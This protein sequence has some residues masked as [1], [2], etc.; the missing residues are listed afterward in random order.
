M[1]NRQ[2]Q[3]FDRLFNKNCPTKPTQEDVELVKDSLFL[4]P[5][6]AEELR[7]FSAKAYR[8]LEE[9]LAD[10]IIFIEGEIDDEPHRILLRDMAGMSDPDAEPIVVNQEHTTDPLEELVYVEEES[11]PIPDEEDARI[12]GLRNILDRYSKIHRPQDVI[13]I[14]SRIRPEKGDE[15]LLSPQIIR[16]MTLLDEHGVD[17]VDNVDEET[18]PDL[19]EQELL[20]L[21][22]LLGELVRLRNKIPVQATTA[23]EPNPEPVPDSARII[24]PPPTGPAPVAEVLPEPVAKPEA[25]RFFRPDFQPPHWARKV[26]S[27]P[28]WN[29]A[30]TCIELAFEKTNSTD[31]AVRAEGTLELARWKQRMSEHKQGC[32]GKEYVLFGDY[33]LTLMRHLKSGLD[34]TSEDYQRIYIN[35]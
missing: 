22:S 2:I 8:G 18:R 19:S 6:D 14:G 33:M 34:P 16:Q 23:P 26:M 1:D 3:A 29:Q 30:R 7:K 32:S 10:Q 24:P 21:R 17:Y 31:N 25:K 12:T 35:P 15:L 9:F 11:P 20:N 13:A 28:Y 5:E 4:D 27:L